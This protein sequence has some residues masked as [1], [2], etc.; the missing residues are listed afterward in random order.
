M[1]N[2][3]KFLACTAQL[4][5]LAFVGL[6]AL[7][8]AL[9]MIVLASTDDARV[10]KVLGA[11]V[12]NGDLTGAN[13]LRSPYGRSGYDYD[14][15][16]ECVALSTN[17]GNEGESLLARAAATPFVGFEGAAPCQNLIDGLKGGSLKPT[18][19]YYRYWHGPTTYLRVALSYFSLVNV[20]VMNALLLIGA[21]AALMAVLVRQFGALAVPFALIPLTAAS[22]ILTAPA[23]TVHALTWIWALLSAA[24]FL[25]RLEKHPALD[26]FTLAFAFILGGVANFLDDLYSPSIAPTLMAFFAVAVTLR[27]ET[28]ARG[29]AGG[30]FTAGAWF[31]GFLSLWIGKWLFAAAVL[32][33]RLVWNDIS[34]SVM[35]R[36]FGN[37]DL[38]AQS[39]LFAATQ[40]VFAALRNG[41]DQ[42]IENAAWLALLIIVV[43]LIRRREKWRAFLPRLGALLLPLALPIIW[44][45]VARDHTLVHPE[46]AYRGL[47]LFAVIPLLAGVWLW[48]SNS[49]TPA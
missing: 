36:T 33:W 42:M 34:V 18:F 10:M 47:F 38:S 25:R 16:G 24:L 13:F 48:K 15:F 11:A 19:A 30:V 2:W 44:V 29:I 5:A 32:G 43:A 1:G 27:R 45:E 6:M 8:I 35:Y 28:V 14:M 40:A 37:D 46:F 20:R 21:A 39:H 49:A 12:A 7:F 23:S 26:H 41:S 17:L 31:A 22:N 4:C 3:G 9:Q